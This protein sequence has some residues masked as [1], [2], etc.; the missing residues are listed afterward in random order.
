MKHNCIQILV[1]AQLKKTFKFKY[2][3]MATNVKLFITHSTTLLVLLTLSY[4]T[5]TMSHGQN[6]HVSMGWDGGS[7]RLPVN[8]STNRATQTWLILL[9]CGVR[10]VLTPIQF[11]LCSQPNSSYVDWFVDWV[12]ALVFHSISF[13]NSAQKMHYGFAIQCRYCY[14]PPFLIIQFVISE[15]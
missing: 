12:C 6:S 2:V 10:N 7:A 3:K 4:N 15:V 14:C 8:S 9:I 5:L 13:C 1:Y 11:V